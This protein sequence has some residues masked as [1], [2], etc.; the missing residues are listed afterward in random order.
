LKLNQVV[1][2]L[3]AARATGVLSVE[4][5]SVKR[6][7]VLQDGFVVNAASNVPYEYL[8][9]FLINLGHITEDQFHQTYL[10]Q[11]ETNIFFGQLLVQ[12]KMVSEATLR[13]VLEMK[14]KETL[15]EAYQWED[16]VVHFSHILPRLPA[17][18]EVSV[19]LSE[20][21]EA[22]ERRKA[23][24]KLIR[25][26]FPHRHFTLK[27]NDAA[28]PEPLQPGTVDAIIIQMAQAGSSIEEISLATHST[29]FFLFSRLYAFHLLG[30]IF[31]GR[32]N[33]GPHVT[34]NES[35][36]LIGIAQ[37]ALM[38]GEY[39]EAWALLRQTK[40]QPTTQASTKL[41]M[42]LKLIWHPILS[43]EWL[44]I[45]KVPKRKIPGLSGFGL[46]SAERYLLSRV[47]GLRDIEALSVVAPLSEFEVLA[48]FD[49]FLGMEYIS[50]NRFYSSDSQHAQAGQNQQSH[51]RK[52]KHGSKAY[53]GQ[54]RHL[55]VHALEAPACEKDP[56]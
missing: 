43:L 23:E 12:A 8:G 7:V 4:H 11:Q 38:Q 27:V 16:A 25:R 34:P 47:D 6:T 48:T 30:V 36:V 51:E 53:G 42:E 28:L 18:L 54:H 15:L 52:E 5:H 17:G 2:E 20:I 45:R 46:T 26:V 33:S 14:Y 29:E 13:A 39:R 56:I 44:H 32:P 31:P 10:V 37:M 1:K 3:L 24:W 9:Q 41:M 40:E 55:Q 50:L 21:D 35:S 19:P 49:Y 22:V